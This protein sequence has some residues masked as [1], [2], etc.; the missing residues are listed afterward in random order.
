MKGFFLFGFKYL[1]YY[2]MEDYFM[3]YNLRLL[4]QVDEFCF[5]VAEW[6]HDWLKH[7]VLQIVL[8]LTKIYS[9]V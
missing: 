8:P 7:R 2:K 5:L 1:K 4:T 6:G 3:V 9:V